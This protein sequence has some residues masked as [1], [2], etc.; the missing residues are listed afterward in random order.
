MSTTSVDAS[1]ARRVELILGQLES[2]PT[3]PAVAM[4]LL[5]LTTN[6]ESESEE[7]VRLI[8][9]DPSLTSKLLSLCRRSN[10]GVR[11]DAISID[12]VVLLLGYNAVRNA[13]LSLK[14]FQ[15]FHA[16]AEEAEALDAASEPEDEHASN[17]DRRGLW[18]HSLAVAICC[19]LLAQAHPHMPELR[20]A[21]AFVCGLLHDIGKVALHMVL[22]R[23]Y[24]R[25]TELAELNQGNVA[26]FE[27]RV[28]GI[29][30]HTAGKRLAEQ[31]QLP[32]EIQ[33]S[34]WLHGSSYELLPRLEHRAL[35]GLVGLA[36][37]V[38]RR[39][40]IGYSGNFAINASPAEMA[41]AMG[42]DPEKVE[43]VGGRLFEEI[44]CQGELLGLEDQ[45][46]QELFLRS[47]QNANE[48]LGRLNAALERRGRAA[49]RQARTLASIASFQ[50]QAGSSAGLQDVLGRVAAAAAEAL[51]QGFYAMVCRGASGEPWLVAQF[52]PDGQM[53]RAK[54]VDPPSRAVQDAWRTAADPGAVGLMA[55][56]PWVTDYLIDASDLHQ[57]RL[58]PLACGDEPTAVLLHDRPTLPPREELEALT[59]TWAAAI[60]A[61]LRN[62]SAKR[63]GEELADANRQLAET[64]DRL[65]DSQT[66]IRLGEMAA[67]AAHEMN[68]PL[69]V[70]SGRSQ[71]L[72]QSLGPGSEEH[73]SAAKIVE[74]SHRL[75]DLISFLRMFADPPR[76]ERS[77]TKIGQMLDELVRGVQA[78]AKEYHKD[79]PLS[80]KV[81]YAAAP[82]MIDGKKVGGAVRELVLNAMQA[83]PKSSVHISAKVGP[84]PDL[85]TIQV[86]DDGLGMERAVI[87]HAMDPFFSSKAAGR[88]TGMGLPRAQLWARAHG[89]EIKLAS[90]PNRGTT[91]TLLI[92]LRDPP[93]AERSK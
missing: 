35:V 2:L 87:E 19:E 52:G 86:V 20:P 36:D 74:Q 50:A 93:G 39:Q 16:G 25:V 9:A 17:F 77:A 85:L 59:L 24:R 66:L 82:V 10:M 76:A 6:E 5:A 46:S 34:I 72:V 38:A 47:I 29:D 84:E 70:I 15:L 64:Q 73:K 91:A 89:G 90:T 37:L 92:P 32:H 61:T 55:L 65:L 23:A 83:S 41:R 88:R 40:H 49:S 28:V 71:L 57:V 27:R 12:R 68:N 8:K 4:R 53:R 21:D 3:L 69:A 54:Y 58:L 56:L 48:A 33:D 62:E 45:P 79:V 51:G 63:L 11:T 7:V 1:R 81:D 67:G 22:P 30:H 14:V 75:S 18:Q 26:E 13:V 44:R 31:W 60:G 78:E 42:L 43:Q 80:L